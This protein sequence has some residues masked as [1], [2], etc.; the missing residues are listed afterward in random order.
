LE[1]NKNNKTKNKMSNQIENPPVVD[2]DNYNIA[3]PKNFYKLRVVE[4]TASVTANG[5]KAYRMKAEITPRV[6][7]NPTLING[8]CIDGVQF[9]HNMVI[10]PKTLKFVNQVRSAL[11]LEALTPETIEQTNPEEYIGLEGFAM[12]KCAKTPENDEE[13]NQLT[14]PYTSAPVF[15]FKRELM[16]WAP[17]PAA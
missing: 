16:E 4:C 9:F 1:L 7:G 17:R 6:E 8:V 15:K 2:A 5:N 10:M 13:G 12:C 3:I 14:D 11:G